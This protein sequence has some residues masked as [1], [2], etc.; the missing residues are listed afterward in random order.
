MRKKGIVVLLLLLL[1]FVLAACSSEPEPEPEPSPEPVPVETV[2][3]EPTPEPE[4]EPY[5]NPLTGELTETDIS[6][7]RPWAVLLN[8]IRVALP[9]N[10]IG[11]A[12]IIY[13][14]PVEGGITRILAVFQDIEGAGEIG[15]VRSVRHY[16]IDVVQ[17]HDAIFVHAGGSPQGYAAIRERGVPNIDGVLGSGREFFR[18]SERQRRAG[19]EHSLMTTDV[20]LLRYVDNYEYRRE[21]EP[22]FDPGFRFTEDAIP[23]D[24]DPAYEISVRFSNVKTGVFTFDAATGLYQ[25][26]QFGGPHIDGNTDEQIAVTNVLVLFADFRVMD[27]EGRLDV[28]LNRGGTGYFATGGRMIPITW[29]KGGYGAPFRFQHADGRPL[30]LAVGRSYV[31]IVNSNTGSVTVE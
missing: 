30:E 13:E 2:E 28:D 17:G 11:Q 9:Q 25:V 20:L 5:R 8:N 27:D 4:P 19:F 7:E 3:P 15:P 31:N 23:Q 26:S 21:H 10:G 16:F 22:S 18:D 24:G 1:L 12:D 6:G 14:M 29:T